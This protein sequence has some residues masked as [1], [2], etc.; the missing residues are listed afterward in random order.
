MSTRNTKELSG[1]DF[2]RSLLDSARADPLPQNVQIA[3]ANFAGTL[4]LAAS[5][6]EPSSGLHTI[7]HPEQAVSHA[8]GEIT[9][10]FRAGLGKAATWFVVGAIG[11]SALTAGLLM[12]HIG[13]TPGDSTRAAAQLVPAVSAPSRE[14][15]TLPFSAVAPTARVVALDAETAASRQ[16]SVS[17]AKTP[18]Q[19]T[20]A[21]LV[22]SGVTD[23]Q[24]DST[25]LSLESTS[26]LSPTESRKS[27]L[28]AQVR[29][30]DAARTAYRIG[31]YNDAIRLVEDYHREFPDGALAP[32]AD[33]VAIESLVGKQ[34]RAA[35]ARYAQ[36]FLAK[37]PKDPHAA[38]VRQW[39]DP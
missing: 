27:T 11:G 38:L 3:W 30:L 2:E 5:H 22:E 32:D 7:K 31:A 34:D 13:G 35:A 23:G 8:R 17:H 29:R 16:T 18:P 9:Q 28:A 19:S 24:V 10:G 26:S 15:P 1:P 12:R 39:S 14:N 33:A 21:N 36:A 37:Y 25:R 4:R 20:G 6:V